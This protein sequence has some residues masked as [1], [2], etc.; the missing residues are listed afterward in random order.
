MPNCRSPPRSKRPAPRGNSA[1]R[2]SPRRAPRPMAPLKPPPWR[3][4]RP[5]KPPRAPAMPSGR[6][7][8][9]APRRCSSRSPAAALPWSGSSWPA[10]ATTIRMTG[11]GR[12][13]TSPSHRWQGDAGSASSVQEP[14][15][16]WQGSPSATSSNGS[17]AWRSPMPRHSIGPSTAQSRGARS[18]STPGA[19]IS[20]GRVKSASIVARS[21]SSAPSTSRRRWRIP[22]PTR[23]IRSPSGCR[24]NRSMAGRGAS[25]STSCPV[26][27]SWIVI[28]RPSRFLAVTGCASAR[29]CPAGSPLPRNIDSC[30]VSTVARRRSTSSSS[31]RPTSRRRSPTPSTARRACRRR[32]GGTPPASPRKC[33]T[34]SRSGTW[35]CGS[36]ASRRRSSAA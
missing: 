10:S 25:H 8:R 29:G 35:R 31:S 34:P 2:T 24:W 21:R 3:P 1:R 13:G 11:A 23:P 16:I 20:P 32:A 22:T 19:G 5:R 15:P 28:G 18:P 14:R 27:G 4:H 9:R 7:I 17:A 6:S 30:P 12:W 36:P 33:G 26:W